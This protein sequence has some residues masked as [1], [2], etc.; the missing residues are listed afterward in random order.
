[1]VAK[2]SNFYSIY[3]QWVNASFIQTAAS[4]QKNS[5]TPVFVQNQQEV[6]I[7]NFRGRT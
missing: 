5:L 3:Y 6:A 4:H 2:N 7:Q 1:M